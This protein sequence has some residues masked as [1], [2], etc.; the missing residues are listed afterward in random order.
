MGGIGY[1]EQNKTACMLSVLDQHPHAAGGARPPGETVP[2]QLVGL[3]LSAGQAD[4]SG[5]SWPARGRCLSGDGRRRLW[6]GKAVQ[7]THVPALHRG[8]R[9]PH[10]GD[11]LSQRLRSARLLRGG[12][13]EGAGGDLPQGNRGVARQRCAH[14]DLGRRRADA[15][16]H[17]YRRLHP[18]HTDD[19]G[20]RY[21]RADQSRLDADGHDQPARRHRRRHRRHQPGTAL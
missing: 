13:R 14:R 20:E 10:P 1:I 2:L 17:V 8:L 12:P 5:Q 11:P 21:C 9:S 6:L 7:R 15:E 3:R 18:G 4:R 19:H 16:F